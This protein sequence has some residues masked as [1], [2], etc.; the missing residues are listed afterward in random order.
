MNEIL[1]KKKLLEFSDIEIKNVLAR[2]NVDLLTGKSGAVLFYLHKFQVTQQ[3]LYLLK[4][5]HVLEICLQCTF[6][7]SSETSFFV[8]PLG[9]L[10]L[11]FLYE[12]VSGSQISNKINYHSLIEG[13]IEVQ[14]EKVK[15]ENSPLDYIYGIAGWFI[16]YP[17]LDE[18]LRSMIVETFKRKALSQ[19]D[20]FIKSNGSLG[21]AHGLTSIYFIIKEYNIDIDEN[22]L[23]KLEKIISKN[24]KGDF[25][26]A[27]FNGS[28]DYVRQDWCH[29]QLG[30]AL[31]FPNGVENI[32]H[33]L[34]TNCH[35]L[36][37]G[38]CHGLGQRFLI[39]KLAY[40]L[41]KR[42]MTKIEIP[43]MVFNFQPVPFIESY[44]VALMSFEL[45]LKRDNKFSW[46]RIC[47]PLNRRVIGNF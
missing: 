16:L 7:Y 20:E 33:Y 26:L 24:I 19:I 21:F 45:N 29:G 5:K 37:H 12:E 23:I 30:L 3:A 34:S 47:Y 17:Y 44:L 28:N 39:N 40:P 11:V 43:Q 18:K 42:P 2:K 35:H 41:L 27:R 10:W 4:A 22:I 9:T 14:N 15:F 25:K 8:G 1:Y 6:K 31:S 38:V 46:W 32:D 36:S 13:Y